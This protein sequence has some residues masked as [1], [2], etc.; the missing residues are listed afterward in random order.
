G[1]DLAAADVVYS[2][3]RARQRSPYASLLGP[4]EGLEAVGPHAVRVQLREPFPP[5]LQNLAEPW[6]AILPREVEERWG[7]FRS[8]Q[9]LV[10]CG[11]FALERYEPGVKAIFARN[12]DYYERGLPHL[13]RVEWI[14]LRDRALQL[15][16][17]RAGEVDVPFHDARIPRGELAS[18]LEATPPHVTRPWDALATRGL[19]MRCDRPPLS[20]VRVRRALSLA[21]NRRAWVRD[22]LDGHGFEDG[23][24][25][26]AP[27][28]PWRLG[29]ADLGEG[30][31]YLS[32][33]PALARTLLAEAGF[34]KGLKLKC[35]H[36]AL[37]GH[38]NA[39]DLERLA[40][41]LKQVAV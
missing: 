12:P 17:F 31:R 37:H 3:E 35:T 33:D 39:E 10:G 22:Y 34:A 41:D 15:S 32:H 26:P 4:V 23:G 18:L 21:V 27:L 2:M 38:D 13:D 7:D 8:A 11:P 1:R 24:P 9:S 40:A 30:A 29:T 36:W 6:N 5:F 20:D 25:V 19:A 16:L 14:F 28:A